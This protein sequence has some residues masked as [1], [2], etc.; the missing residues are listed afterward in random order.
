MVAE[1]GA[2]PRPGCRTP[3]HRRQPR[4]DRG[5]GRPH[6][7]CQCCSSPRPACKESVPGMP[8]PPASGCARRRAVPH[9]RPR[10]RSCS[11]RRDLADLPGETVVCPCEGVTAW[12]DHAERRQIP[13]RRETGDTGRHGALRRAVLRRGDRALLRCRH[14]RG[15]FL[16]A[17]P[18]CAS[19]ARG[20]HHGRPPRTG[21]RRRPPC[22]PPTRWLTT[23]S[24]TPLPGDAEILVIGGGIV[25]LA[26]A[27]FLAREGRDVLLADR[28]EPG[29]AA[30]TANA[31][32]LA[33][34]VGALRLRRR[35][36]RAD[37]RRVAARTRPVLAAYGRTSPATPTRAWE[38]ESRE[39]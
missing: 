15:F 23:A 38:Y 7:P 2:G 32:S 16:R 34:P 28:G 24:A 17:A 30:S 5:H 18:A 33:R 22:R 12:A 20:R 4:D 29:L 14:G 8:P 9:G 19:R 26:C 3:R 27:L 6:Q 31:G 35:V 37:G 21:R 10:H 11:T 36:G 39:G 25:G 1:T 13:R